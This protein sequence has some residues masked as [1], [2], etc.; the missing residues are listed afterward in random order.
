MSFTKLAKVCQS[1]AEKTREAT[2]LLSSK[3]KEDERGVAILINDGKAHMVT[4]PDAGKI[5]QA[6]LKEEREGKLSRAALETLAIISYRQPITRPKI[7][8][9]RGVNSS[10]MLR[11]LLLRGLIER[12]KSSE[13]QRMFEYTLSF[14]FMKLIGISKREELPEFEEL[15]KSLID[16]GLEMV[17]KSESRE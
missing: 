4:A 13:D 7:D 9:I 14:E 17:E 8:V 6:F 12:R 15:T 1:D 10:I 3:L 16:K 11:S 5:V 2:E